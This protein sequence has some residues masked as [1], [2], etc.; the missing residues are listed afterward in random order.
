MEAVGNLNLFTFITER[1]LLH[2]EFLS[3]A[4]Y[5]V[6]LEILVERVVPAPSFVLQNPANPDYRYVG[7][8]LLVMEEVRFEN[9]MMLKVMANL[10]QQSKETEELMQVKKQFL[11]DLVNMCRGVKE[12][13]RTILQMSVWQEWLISLTY[14]YPTTDAEV[15]RSQL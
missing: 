8:W 13:R 5:N 15:P 10:I 11:L 12:N 6:L 14:I 2:S 7:F 3:I 4:T 9:P 1:L